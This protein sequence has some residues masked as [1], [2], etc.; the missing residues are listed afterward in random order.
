V[1]L[2]VVG[3]LGDNQPVTRT[4][5]PLVGRS[6]E[7]AELL[8]LLGQV[9]QG[10]SAAAVIGGDAGVGKTRLITELVSRAAERGVQ[11]LVGHCVDL[12]DAPP[13]YLP[14]AEAFARLAAERPDVVEQLIVDLPAIGR[15]LPGRTGSDPDD[16]L[17]RGELFE[18]IL[19]ALTRLGRSAPVLLVIE[20]VH[21]ADQ[22]TRDLLGFLLARLHD[23]AVGLALTYRSDD[24]HRRHPL[25]PLLAQWAR[26][27]SVSRIG[28][29]RLPPVDLRS[30]VEAVST[31]PLD[32][33]DIATIVAR[34]DGN[35]FF[36]EELVAAAEQC[37]DSEHLP[38][39][40]AD[41]LLVR[42]DRLGNDSRS[43][44]RAAAVAGREVSH[45]LIADVVGLPADRL[46][47]ALRD[48][49]DAHVLEVSNSGRGY[50]FRH[51]LLAEAVYD[52]L[53]PGE[54]TRLHARYAE[55]L[56]G[57][58]DGSAAEL[59]RH[60]RASHDLETALTA[61]VRAAEEALS[62]AAPQQALQHVE[63]ALSLAP[64]ADLAL[65][66]ELVVLMAEAAHASGR[67]RRGERIARSALA[68]LPDDAPP[69]IRARLLYAQVKCAVAGEIDTAALAATSE[70]LRL[71][72]GHEEPFRADLLA[73]HALV[74]L[75][76]GREVESERAVEETLQVAA[77]T[78]RTQAATE[79]QTT[80]AILERR[81]G[82]PEEAA[83]LLTDV[84]DRTRASGDGAAELRSRFSL[85]S[86]LE[87]Q[88][89]LSAAEREFALTAERAAELGRPWEVFGLSSRVQ[90][91]LLQHARNDWA[92][93]LRTLD[94]AG[95]RPPPVPE[96]MLTAAR[97]VVRASRAD[98]GVLDVLPTLRPMWTR[99][100][101]IA[102]HSARAQLQVHEYTGDW[103]AAI[104][105]VD[106]AV[107]VIGVVWL[108]PWFLAR[109]EFSTL[110]L[111]A[112]SK[113][114]DALPTDRRAELAEPGQRLLDDGRR[115]SVEGLPRARVLGVEGQAWVAR[116]EAEGLRLRW[117]IGDNPP[118]AG[119][120][121][122]AWE[123]AVRAFD[124]GNAVQVMRCRA[125][126][127]AILRAVGRAPEA[128]A[129]G[130]E[131]RSVAARLGARPVLDEIAPALDSARPSR[132]EPATGLSALTDRERD[133]LR[134][135]QTGHSNRQIGNKLYISEK[136][137][138]VH[139][140]NILAKLGVRSRTEAAALARAGG[141]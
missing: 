50:S 84:I 108:D 92:T 18:S 42:L 99:D 44:V 78:G 139:V 70:A 20:D 77:R 46:E 90:A 120:L 121:V 53:L 49:L 140:S 86:L 4:L 134:L 23:D 131:V 93:A 88:G 117:L 67:A 118:D 21:W 124:Y 97:M 6:A 37:A 1:T 60:A 8:D 16:R 69:G 113:A 82:R 56:A 55:L 28:V 109:I 31:Q 11:V 72:A 52:D 135:V 34:A 59:A 30:V 35:A 81:K 25:R 75:I 128:A 119:E 64:P 27:P 48:A 105:V 13:P 29:Q 141:S 100:G 111:G 58:S 68:D 115:S 7:L 137:V 85:G 114:A 41:L 9:T 43:V 112:L 65:R 66:A 102:L 22:S 57:R 126:L 36:A 47:A 80:R 71:T 54:R 3:P 116:L 15:L 19:A 107:S 89:D 104:D 51:A 76:M 17:G 132:R 125:R 62:L 5:A 133:V 103:R 61:S 74:A 14:F 73:L 123:K 32:E 94:P 2:V 106:D 110:A 24:L 127:A 129:V 63:T 39:D 83:A 38:D 26:I 33:Y 138:S 96:A 79:V 40:L 10:G 91:G 101:R 122:A 45:D 130:E 95:E 12:G 98:T 87:E 136:T